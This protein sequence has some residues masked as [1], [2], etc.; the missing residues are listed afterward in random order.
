MKRFCLIG[1]LLFSILNPANAQSDSNSPFSISVALGRQKVGL[2]FYELLSFP[3]HS[4]YFFEVCRYY[5]Q[6]G[7]SSWYQN[8]GLN[9]YQN[10]SAGSGY[11]LQTHTGRDLPIGKSLILS[12]EGG[13]GVSH[14]FHPKEIYELVDGG[15][16]L[17]RDLGKIRPSVNLKILLGYQTQ[18]ALIYTSYQVS[19]EFFYNEDN[20]I[21]PSNFLQLGIRYHLKS[22]ER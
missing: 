11:I 10:N 9:I 6:Q 14:S 1:I 7:T 13:I 22:S 2:P 18:L 20:L 3:P 16:T 17:A 12:P 19:A 15:Y 8:I 21:L 5:G 4:S